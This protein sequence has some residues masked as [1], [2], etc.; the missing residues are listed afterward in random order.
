MVID[1]HGHYIPLLGN[2]DFKSL[3]CIEEDCGNTRY[4]RLNGNVFA[5]LD[6]GLVSLEKHME[7]M[8][9][10]GID[11]RDFQWLLSCS[12]MSFNAMRLK[13]G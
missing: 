6:E 9:R 10:A 12:I 5:K 2:S 7:D 1:I 11:H 4:I 13:M 3:F 8:G